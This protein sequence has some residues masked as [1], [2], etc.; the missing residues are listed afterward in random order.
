[1]LSLKLRLM[2]IRRNSKSLVAFPDSYN[3]IFSYVIFAIYHELG[4]P[5]T[6]VYGNKSFLATKGIVKDEGKKSAHRRCKI[7]TEKSK[8]HQNQNKVESGA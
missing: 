6:V 8:I 2:R 1:V 7:T 5:R 4:L 3:Y